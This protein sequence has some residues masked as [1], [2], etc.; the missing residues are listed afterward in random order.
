M[1]DIAWTP[2]PEYVERANVTRL[3]RAHGITGLIRGALTELGATTRA[4]KLEPFVR[5][6]L[7]VARLAGARAR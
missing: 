7:C 6:D 2:S 3:M 5:P 1:T 4:T